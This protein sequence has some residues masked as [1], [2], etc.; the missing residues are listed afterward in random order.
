MYV[1]YVTI[2]S[3]KFLSKP[4]YNSILFASLNE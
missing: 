4:K 2:A 1:P 3:E